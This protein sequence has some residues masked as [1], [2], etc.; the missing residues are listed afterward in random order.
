MKKASKCDGERREKVKS[1]K[2]LVARPV[3]IVT[4][5]SSA[6]GSVGGMF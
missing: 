3:P 5:I 6:V 2:L 4:K 1:N